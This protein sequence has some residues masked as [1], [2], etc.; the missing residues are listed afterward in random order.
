MINLRLSEERGYENKGWLETYHTF[1]F[2]TYYDPKYVGFHS[3]RVIN[4]DTVVGGKGFAAHAHHDM[5][6][7]TY[8]LEGVL[9][10]KDSMGNTG[11]I[12]PG[13]VQR[14]SAGTGVTHSEYNLSHHL[15]VHFFQ[16]WINPEQHNIEP[17]YTQKLF[18]SASKW[19]QWCLMVSRNGREGSLRVHQDADLYSTI[20]DSGDEIAF[21]ALVDRHYWIQILHGEFSL[22]GKTLKK[23]DGA[24]IEEESSLKIQ[25]L[26]GGELIL[27]DLA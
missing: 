23:G 7:I 4:E 10:H 26:K 14:M 1:S 21:E 24:A 22:L 27:F 2:D 25:C 19:G 6:I 20:L 16:M 18:S 17:S 5:E 9:E 3:L 8:V 13:E 15:P 12:R 11:I